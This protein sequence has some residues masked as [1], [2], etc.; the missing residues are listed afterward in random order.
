MAGA[1][2]RRV[3]LPP[4]TAP[5]RF[6]MSPR[7]TARNRTLRAIVYV[8]VSSYDVNAEEAANQSPEVQR[9]RCLAR[10]RA[11]R[12]E[13]AEDIGEGGVILDLDV[14]GSDKGQRLNRLGLLTARQ[15]IR[16]RRADV[17]GSLR[18]DPEYRAWLMAD[19]H[20]APIDAG[21]LDE[22]AP[23]FV[24]YADDEEL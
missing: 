22:P 10:I 5:G 18:L 15:T 4:G 24:G 21:G 1:T 11:E 16:D 8:R 13:L 9:E 6:P 14:S 20:A 17:I 3:A 12:W 19:F 7:K 2:G 23:Y